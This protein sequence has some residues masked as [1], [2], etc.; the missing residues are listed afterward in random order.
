MRSEIVLLKLHLLNEKPVLGARQIYDPQI[1]WTPTSML[2]GPAALGLYFRLSSIWSVM[3]KTSMLLEAGRRKT[4][5]WL[6]R[7]TCCYLFLIFVNLQLAFQSLH[8]GQ[9]ICSVVHISWPQGNKQFT[10]QQQSLRE[11]HRN[12]SRGRVHYE[13]WNC[14]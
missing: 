7:F 1:H 14:D 5:R 2:L 13:P 10:E 8:M 3:A 4:S 11:P 12:S 6:I 9:L